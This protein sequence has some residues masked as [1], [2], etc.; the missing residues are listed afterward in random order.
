MN[1]A[2]K[3]WAIVCRAL[4]SGRQIVILRKGGI[5]EDG[6]QFKPEYPEFLLFPTYSHQSTENVIP[7]A[8]VPFEDLEKEQPEAGQIIFRHAATVT[9]ALKMEDLSALAAFRGEHVWSEEVVLER[10]HRWKDDSVY[11][12]VV[13]ISELPRP[14]TVDLKEEYTGCKSWVHLE[15]DVPVASARPVIGEV[16]FGRRVQAVRSA[17]L[18][19]RT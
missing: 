7:E 8:R 16:D 10:F 11:A 19:S 5:V 17:L 4:A 2:F 1:I 15:E 13:R 12:L 18:G 14:V 6:G 9:E 3:E